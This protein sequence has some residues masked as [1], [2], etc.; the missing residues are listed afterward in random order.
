MCKKGPPAESGGRPRRRGRKGK[1]TTRKDA[2]E[3]DEEGRGQE[4]REGSS[5]IL[6]LGDGLMTFEVANTIRQR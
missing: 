1:G 5:T 4:E 3:G 2:A 6:S